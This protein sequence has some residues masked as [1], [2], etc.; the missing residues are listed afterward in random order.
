MEGILRILRMP[1]KS[2]PPT[3][4]P[5]VSML[6]TRPPKPSSWFYKKTEHFLNSQELM[7]FHRVLWLIESVAWLFFYLL[8]FFCFLLPFLLAVFQ[9]IL[10]FP[11][12]QPFLLAVGMPYYFDKLYKTY[13]QAADYVL[14]IYILFITNRF[15]L[16][17]TLNSQAHVSRS[18]K[19]AGRWLCF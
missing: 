9:I 14:Y 2:N 1:E 5:V 12:F 13:E 10:H 15:K 8:F 17:F 19:R 4:F 3:R 6:T 11:H 16:Y 7:A 18:P